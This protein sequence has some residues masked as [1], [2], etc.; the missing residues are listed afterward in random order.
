VAIVDDLLAHPG[1]YIGIDMDTL[2][3]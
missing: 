3:R 2:R 1:L